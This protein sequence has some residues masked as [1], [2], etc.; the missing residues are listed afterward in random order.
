LTNFT[1]NNGFL[2]EDISRAISHGF[3]HEF[4][5]LLTEFARTITV[6]ALS[7]AIV[8]GIAYV[9]SSKVFIL[10]TSGWLNAPGFSLIISPLENKTRNAFEA[11]VVG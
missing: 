7:A 3:S 6:K 11:Q 5:S 1:G 4:K 2:T 9:V 10:Q 8:T